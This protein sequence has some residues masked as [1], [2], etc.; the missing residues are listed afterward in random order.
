MD[1]TSTQLKPSDHVFSVP[2][3]NG[4]AQYPAQQSASET[5]TNYQHPNVQSEALY[6]AN[7]NILDSSLASDLLRYP[8]DKLRTGGSYW[9]KSQGSK[10][11]R[12]KISGSGDPE[13]TSSSLH[14]NTPW[15]RKSSTIYPTIREQQ[16]IHFSSGDQHYPEKFHGSTEP[17]NRLGALNVGTD[18]TM[19]NSVSFHT[20]TL[21][22]QKR[23]ANQQ[24]T[25]G[26]VKGNLP[27]SMKPIR[28]QSKHPFNSGHGLVRPHAMKFG[29]V[30]EG[31]VQRNNQIHD[32]IHYQIE[33]LK[34]A[35]NNEI[36]MEE[37]TRRNGNRQIRR[38]LEPLSHTNDANNIK[39][40]RHYFHHGQPP[41][42]IKV[43][44]RLGHRVVESNEVKFGEITEG[45]VQRNNQI[46]DYI[47]SRIEAL[48]AAAKN[49]IATEENTRRNDNRQIR[50]KPEQ[51]LSHINDANNIK[52]WRHSFHH[53]QS[54]HKGD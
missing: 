15:H 16:N 4:P 17:A 28:H 31:E 13:G 2:R 50:R 54:R 9:D 10:E 38:K 41:R 47:H 11:I 52:K 3:V 36:A 49:E 43:D 39:E 19:K 7:D 48:K 34:A 42:E 25:A 51:P 20:D 37:N 46:H 44:K 24:G 35:A 8:Y 23:G 33:T 40:W 5:D 18:P 14:H 21:E 12:S 53:R 45:E 32:Y 1:D 6:G 29:E 22:V 27:H 30:T 26:K